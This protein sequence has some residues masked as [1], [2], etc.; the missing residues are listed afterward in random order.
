[1]YYNERGTDET[2]A[3]V[4]APAMC[5]GGASMIAKTCQ[6]GSSRRR[7]TFENVTCLNRRGRGRSGLTRG[8][9]KTEREF[10]GTFSGLAGKLAWHQTGARARDRLC[11]S[12]MGL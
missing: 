6:S 9:R 11:H 4:R 8:I 2:L 3:P 1:V 10:T 12:I 5:Q 7:S